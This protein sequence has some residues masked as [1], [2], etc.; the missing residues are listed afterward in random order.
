[1]FVYDHPNTGASTYLQENMHLPI[2]RINCKNCAQ[3][4]GDHINIH[5]RKF[6]FSFKRRPLC[7]LIKAIVD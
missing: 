7:Y 3:Y 6:T 1:M 4:P 5:Y 2:A